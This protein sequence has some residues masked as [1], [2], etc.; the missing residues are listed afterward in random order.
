[1][2]APLSGIRTGCETLTSLGCSVCLLTWPWPLQLLPSCPGQTCD[3]ASHRERSPGIRR[4]FWPSLYCSVLGYVV[5]S[6]WPQCAPPKR[7]S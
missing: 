3:L 2:R 6:P 4:L 1:M 7:G 5:A